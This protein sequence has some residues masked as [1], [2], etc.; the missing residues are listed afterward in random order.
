M[1]RRTRGLPP[2][3][4]RTLAL[5]SLALLGLLALVA[6]ASRGGRPSSGGGGAREP[7]TAFWDYA[8]S[9]TL[10]LAVAALGIAIWTVATGKVGAVERPTK[11]RRLGG[12]VFLVAV[13]VAL[14]I[15]A[16]QMDLDPK[17]LGNDQSTSGRPTTTSS[18]AEARPQRARPPELRWAPVLL[19]GAAGL[20]T[21]AV[22]AARSRAR[23]RRQ[24][25]TSDLE[26][27]DELAT[28][29]DET[30]DDLRAEPDPRRAVI[31]AY[32]RTER[33][34]AANGLPRRSF[35]APLEYLDRIAAPL[36]ERV[37]SARRLVFELTHLYERAKF[38]P[39]AIDAEM[40]ADAI[41]TLDTLRDELRREEVVA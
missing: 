13:L 23:L 35:E 1:R 18:A 32:A 25:P 21:V 14:V 15:A 33:A 24:A 38:S 29:L 27:A 31:A 36:H 20:A 30:L 41:A 7:A 4:A 5:L 16:R 2:G 9:T 10:A 3:P 8:F 34:L 40:K 17:S 26:L 39:H 19:L 22:L 11:Q 28:L 6:V 12:V 37:P